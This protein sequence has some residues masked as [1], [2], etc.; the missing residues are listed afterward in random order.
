ML[1]DAEQRRLAA[2]EVRLRTDDPG[3]AQ[4]FTSGW[5]RRP[6]DRSRAVA[7][8]MAVTVAVAAAGIGLVL[9]SVATVV[10]ALTTIGA[11]AGLWISNRRRPPV[12][13]SAVQTFVALAVILFVTYGIQ[14]VGALIVV[15]VFVARFFARRYVYAHLWVHHEGH[16]DRID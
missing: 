9:G 8:L 10:I 15:A 7:A 13:A 5:E 6:R 1:S 12:L 2:I 14:A 3:F 4:Q 11:A 16:G